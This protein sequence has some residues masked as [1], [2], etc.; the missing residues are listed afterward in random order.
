MTKGHVK[1]IA[2]GQS[3]VERTWEFAL[4]DPEPA[5]GTSEKPKQRAKATGGR[6]KLR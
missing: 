5:E 6:Q 4:A 1:G 2:V 3:G